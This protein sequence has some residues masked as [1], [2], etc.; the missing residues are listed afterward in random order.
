M[1]GDAISPPQ[2]PLKVPRIGAT[3][4]VARLALRG[5]DLRELSQK[6]YGVCADRRRN[7]AL[8]EGIGGLMVPLECPMHRRVVRLP[9]RRIQLAL[10]FSNAKRVA[11]HQSGKGLAGDDLKENGA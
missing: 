6:R 11:E 9:L 1:Q 10:G 8:K 5:V 2:Y 3:F 7:F 4:D